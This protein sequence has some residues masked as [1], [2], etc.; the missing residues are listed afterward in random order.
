MKLCNN[1]K[2]RFFSVF[3]GRFKGYDYAG[4]NVHSLFRF[5]TGCTSEFKRSNPPR[6][7]SLKVRCGVGVFLVGLCKLELDEL[8]DVFWFFEVEHGSN[9]LLLVQDPS[10]GE[11]E[12]SGEQ[13]DD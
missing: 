10:H 6:Y 5:P 4:V 2:S 3:N 11:E 7:T 8:G 9:K 13:G 12:P 1:S